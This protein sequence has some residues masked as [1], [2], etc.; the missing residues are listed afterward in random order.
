M[1]KPQI[2]LISQF[3][4]AVI[5]VTKKVICGNKFNGLS[6]KVLCLKQIDIE[7]NVVRDAIFFQ[8]QR[9]RFR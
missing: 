7:L 2:L 4:Y 6:L 8:R 5:Y 9:I 3:K 1:L